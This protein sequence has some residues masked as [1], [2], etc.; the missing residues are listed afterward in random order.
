MLGAANG[1][2]HDN[3]ASLQDQ[4]TWVES[5]PDELSLDLQAV[6]T[7]CHDTGQ[8]RRRVVGDPARLVPTLDPAKTAWV[9]HV[10]PRQPAGP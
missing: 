4:G 9:Q 2:A 5:R 8:Y 1:A 6:F 7:S 10:L 3:A